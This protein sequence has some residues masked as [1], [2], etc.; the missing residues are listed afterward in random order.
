M[1]LRETLAGWRATP[2]IG[3][4]VVGLGSSNTEFT[5]HNDGRPSWFCWVSACLRATYGKHVLATN[6]GISGETTRHLIARFARDVVPLAPSLVLV[7]IGGNDAWQMP[8]SEFRRNLDTL[9][10]A[11]R[12]RDAVPVLQT[13]YCPLFAGE[14]LAR[15]EQFMQGVRDVA[16]GTGT[17]LIDHFARFRAR[18]LAAPEAYATLMRDPMHLTGLGHAVFAT[19]AARSLGCAPPELPGDLAPAVTHALRELSAGADDLPAAR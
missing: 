17:D 9:V 18:R 4:R 11:I 8:A 13:Y 14:E 12:A 2:E 1:N 10:D 5:W 19:L 16:A 6:A 3:R 7:T 15:F